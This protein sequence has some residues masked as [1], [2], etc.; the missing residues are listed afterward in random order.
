MGSGSAGTSS[1]IV[2]RNNSFP[3]T[4]TQQA[5]PRGTRGTAKA[6]KDSW[7]WDQGWVGRQT[8]QLTLKVRQ[9]MLEMMS[10]SRW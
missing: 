6:G 1:Q 2:Y 7:K 8:H 5:V 4:H 10:L 9:P 3:C